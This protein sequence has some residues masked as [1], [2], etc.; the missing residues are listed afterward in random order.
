LNTL[1]VDEQQCTIDKLPATRLEAHRLGIKKYFTSKQCTRGHVAYR[2]VASGV[3]SMCASD[4]AKKAWANGVR[5]KFIDRPAINKNWNH[6]EKAKNAKNRWKEKNPKRAWAVYATGAAKMRATLK[7]V[8]F[9]LTSNYVESI[10][11]DR[12]PIFG[13]PFLFIGNKTMQPLSAS[14]DR[15]DPSKGYVEDNVVVISVKA[16][17]IK[18]A[19]GSKEVLAVGS[20]LQQYGF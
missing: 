5:Q 1:K 12:C 8:A 4:K 15:L 13:E 14:L 17:S 11:P 9:N 6:S 20:W 3:C 7:G 18:N 19:Y 16:N 2:Y 10:T